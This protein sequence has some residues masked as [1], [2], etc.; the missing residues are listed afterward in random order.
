MFTR[1]ALLC[2]SLCGYH[3]QF[4]GGGAALESA[5]GLRRQHDHHLI[6]IYES[7]SQLPVLEYG[8]PYSAT[9]TKLHLS[10]VAI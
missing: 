3:G 8:V 10:K 5:H 7:V 9:P 1:L 4:I 6:T 2:A